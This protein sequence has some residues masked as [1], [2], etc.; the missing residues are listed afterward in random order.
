MW[1]GKSLREERE[2][3]NPCPP[4]HTHTYK[5]NKKA[6]EANSFSL[7]TTQSCSHLFA[8]TPVHSPLI[9]FNC[10]HAYGHPHAQ[11]AWL[12]I[13]H[14]CLKELDPL[15]AIAG[16]EEGH[17]HGQSIISAFNT[18]ASKTPHT[19]THTHLAPL[20]ALIYPPHGILLSKKNPSR[21]IQSCH[22]RDENIP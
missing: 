4:P 6:L 14:R 21:V 13:K 18:K 3:W 2:S 12:T 17:T 10:A 7:H 9:T 20:P 16:L 15:S 1:P 22:S 19:Q 5:H 11:Q 8:Y